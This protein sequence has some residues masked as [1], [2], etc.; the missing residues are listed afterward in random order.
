[1][2]TAWAVLAAE[3]PPHCAHMSTHILDIAGEDGGGGGGSP[4][5]GAGEGDVC[6]ICL[7]NMGP[8]ATLA[9][10]PCGHRFMALCLM[11]L[12]AQHKATCPQTCPLCRAP[13]PPAPRKLFDDACRIYFPLKERVEASGQSWA[14]LGGGDRAAMNEVLRLWKAAADQVTVP[15]LR[16]RAIQYAV[17]RCERCS[18]L[19]VPFSLCGA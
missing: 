9:V 6:S 2:A 17:R 14:Q 12:R 16:T 18:F 8:S 15:A 5:S 4:G 7:E 3:T 11:Q 10:L 1:M 13:L 19:R